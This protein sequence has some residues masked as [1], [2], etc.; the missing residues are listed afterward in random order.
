MVSWHQGNFP[1]AACNKWIEILMQPYS[2]LGEKTYYIYLVTKLSREVI[3]YKPSYRVQ[4]T[5]KHYQRRRY[6]RKK[7]HRGVIDVCPD[8]QKQI[9]PAALKT[10]NRT[11]CQG[12]TSSF[13]ECL[14]YAVVMQFTVAAQLIPLSRLL[15]LL[16]G[17]PTSCCML[18]KITWQAGPFNS[19]EIPACHTTCLF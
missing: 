8:H 13:E 19:H 4:I 5:F 14:L 2:P 11:Q 17:F 15:K 7:I 12:A 16:P 9:S 1:K 18:A 3:Y 10:H 6:R